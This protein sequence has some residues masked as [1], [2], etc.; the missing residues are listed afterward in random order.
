[1]DRLT[2]D[3]LILHKKQYSRSLLFLAVQLIVT[4]AKV[5]R[6]GGVRAVIAESLLLKHQLL[7]S[8]RSRRR[9]PPLTTIDR[10]VLG[11]MT[12]F[13]SPR[14]VAKLAAVLKP[15]TLL[16]FHKALVDR[17][18][19]RLFSSAGVRSKLGPK[20]PT[21]ELASPIIKMKLRNPSFGHQRIAQQISLSF[22]VEIDKDVVRRVLAKYFNS[23]HPGSS[24]PS[25]LTLFAETKD[26]LWSADLF[27]CESILLRSH[28]VL[29]VMDVFT[30]RIM[31][32]ASEAN[33]STDRTFAVCS[34]RPLPS[35]RCQGD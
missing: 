5:M 14:R 30:R 29:V 26:S 20:G 13:V 31:D 23:G 27:R 35:G 18:Y 19:R 28:W 21:Q 17:K 3:R 32:S 8:R 11:L 4:L 22:G 34:T 16:R 25:W 12:L 7:V 24:G 33:P 10:F 15:V 1:V 2:R 6:P 9:A